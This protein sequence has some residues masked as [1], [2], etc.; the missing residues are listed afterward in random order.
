MENAET[1]THGIG[2]ASGIHRAANGDGGGECIRK[3]DGKVVRRHASHRKTHYVNAVTIHRRQIEVSVQQFLYR[4]QDGSDLL[5]HRHLRRNERRRAGG[6]CPVILLRTLRHEDKCRI[7][8]T[9]HGVEKHLST[10]CQLFLV[11]APPLAGTVQKEH[12]RILLPRLFRL[13]TKQT[14]VQRISPGGD[15]YFFLIRLLRTGTHGQQ[16]E[17]EEEKNKLF[18]GYSGLF[19]ILGFGG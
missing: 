11:V 16:E 4:T 15:E 19:Y 10:V 12:Q 8:L 14:V 3:A 5:S 18:H 7:L 13:R 6:V 1:D 17:T 2:Q 9:V